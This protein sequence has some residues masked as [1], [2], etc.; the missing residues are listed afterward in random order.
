MQEEGA[1]LGVALAWS[2][3]HRGD[4]GK[5]WEASPAE[6]SLMFAERSGRDRLKLYLLV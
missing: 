5:R 4:P 3:Q 1:S 6:S 2:V